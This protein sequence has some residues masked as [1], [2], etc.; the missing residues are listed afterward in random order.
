MV[1]DISEYTLWH[2]YMALENHHGCWVKLWCF[3]ILTMLNYQRKPLK[4][5]HGRVDWGM[6]IYVVIMGTEIPHGL[7]TFRYTWRFVAGKIIRW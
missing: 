1:R 4:I 2:I 3:F 5:K 6:T 7:M